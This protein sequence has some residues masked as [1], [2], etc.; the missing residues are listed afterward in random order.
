M[1]ALCFFMLGA[2]LIWPLA[3]G[4]SAQA[5]NEH[6]NYEGNRTNLEGDYE[7]GGGSWQVP[8]RS[9]GADGYTPMDVEVG[10]V[11]WSGGSV[12]IPIDINQ[13]ARVWVV[14]YEPH[15]SSW[16]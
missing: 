3:D 12:E 15:S 4:V 1:R 10:F 8:T 7:E 6:P 13:R 16:P 11:E 9:P 14:I 2:A 5:W